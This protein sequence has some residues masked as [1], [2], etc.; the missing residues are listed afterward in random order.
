M[1]YGM[2]DRNSRDSYGSSGGY[3]GG[4][5][6]F[7]RNSGGGFGGNRFAP[8]KQGE[9]LDVT[10]EAVGAKGD[11]IA[12]KN[13]FVIFVPGV[14]AGDTVHIKI[15]RVLSKVAFGEVA[16]AGSA[17]AEGEISTEGEAPAE[18]TAPTEEGTVQS[19]NTETSEEQSADSED[20]GE[21][22]E[23]A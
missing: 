3:G 7:R 21:E 20:F 17:P 5:G 23:E 22:S 19:E 15:T 16:T 18:G 10:I 2:N 8:V 14:K 13:G 12:K 4:G 9:E 11:G 6:G 1:G